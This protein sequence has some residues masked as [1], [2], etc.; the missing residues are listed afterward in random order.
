MSKAQEI[1][2]KTI[3]NPMQGWATGRLLIFRIKTTAVDTVD[4]AAF[5]GEIHETRKSFIRLL[6]DLQQG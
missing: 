6:A 5:W 2:N 4:T 1:L 3:G